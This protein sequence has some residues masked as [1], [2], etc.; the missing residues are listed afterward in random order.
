M[1]TAALDKIYGLILSSD[2]QS[3]IKLHSRI[4][5]EWNITD[6]YKL[7]YT[8]IGE[9]LREN[10]EVTA[11]TIITRLRSENK[12]DKSI[13]LK[14]SALTSAL[15]YDDRL[16][17]NVFFSEMEY[18]Y[19]NRRADVLVNQ[20]H[21]AMQNEILTPVKYKEILESNLKLDLYAEE[22]K[23]AN[24]DTFFKVIGEHDKAKRGEVTGVELGYMT[25]HRKVLLEPVDVM[26]IGARPAMGKTAFAISTAV[27]MACEQK[28][29]VAFFA[30]EMSKTQVMRRIIANL[31]QVDSNRIKYGEC[32]EYEMKKIYQ[33][34]DLPELENIE[35]YEGTH[36]I[37]EIFNKVAKKQANGGVDLVIIDYL[38][39]VASKGNQSR[40]EVVSGASNGIK[41]MAQSLGVPVIAMAQLS[42]DNAKLGKRPSLPDLRESGEIEQDA[43]IV[44]F[45]HRPEY[46]GEELMESGVPSDNMAEFIIAKNREG[47]VGVNEMK[48]NL[49][50]SRFFDILFTDNSSTNYST[51]F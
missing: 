30:L 38:Q 8:T 41:S 31:A 6:F 9:M 1:K 3:G 46:Y 24:I 49:K 21:D 51:P 14:L 29:K 7:I 17:Y 25:L 42:R 37:Q 15:T 45:I 47:E 18:Q 11:M 48:V 32:N 27:K 10:I 36:T 34:Q 44:A 40:Y 19:V 50:T 4:N 33:I 43:S 39:K 13:V 35:I 26:V 2:I 16:H 20:I 23:E 28:L 22:E 12:F 5:A